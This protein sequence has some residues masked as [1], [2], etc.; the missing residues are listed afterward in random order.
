ME[1]LFKCH[2]VRQVTGYFVSRLITKNL[3]SSM[4]PDAAEG[5]LLKRRVGGEEHGDGRSVMVSNLH[6]VRLSGAGRGSAGDIQMSA[7]HVRPSRCDPARIHTYIYFIS[8][9]PFTQ[10]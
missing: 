7:E 8:N 5:E 4:V 6:D 9:L 3:I 2:G 10:R 1:I